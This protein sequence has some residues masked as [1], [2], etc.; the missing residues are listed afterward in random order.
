ML[1]II[2]RHGGDFSL[3]DRHE[4]TA[5][6]IATSLGNTR[7]VKEILNYWNM[8][9]S[10]G[11]NETIL[12]YAARH[13]N[14]EVARYAFLISPKKCYNYSREPANRPFLTFLGPKKSFLLGCKEY[15]T[16]KKKF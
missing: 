1:Y 5:L 3:L 13:N 2:Y 4:E 6:M 8:Y 11:N 12:H 9:I 16:G 14:P 10:S 7:A 15:S